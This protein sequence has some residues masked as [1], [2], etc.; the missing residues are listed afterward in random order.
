MPIE[1]GKLTLSGSKL[2]EQEIDNLM[3]SIHNEINKQEPVKK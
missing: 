2:S 1:D 3:Q